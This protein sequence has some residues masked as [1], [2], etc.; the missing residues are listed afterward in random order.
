[1]DGWLYGSM[2]WPW[3]EAQGEWSRGCTLI[4][5]FWISVSGVASSKAS[6]YLH[7][8]Q[9]HWDCAVFLVTNCH[10]NWMIRRDQKGSIAGKAQPQVPQCMHRPQSIVYTA[11]PTVPLSHQYCIQCPYHRSPLPS[12]LYTVSLP[13]FPSPISIVYSVPTT[14]HLSHQCCI[15]NNSHLALPKARLSTVEWQH[16]CYKGTECMT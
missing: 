12:V 11:P 8:L 7:T 5:Q 2:E 4:T 9:D 14:V 16:C 3:K 6:P 1:M 13:P 15:A 10:G